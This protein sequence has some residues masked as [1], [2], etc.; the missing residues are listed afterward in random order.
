M[1]RIIVTGA[2][3]FIGRHA[4]KTLIAQNYEVHAITSRAIPERAENVTWHQVSLHD[5]R[6]TE[7]IFRT[8]RATHLLHFAW[9]VEHG[10]FWTSTE[11]YRWVATSLHL[12]KAF[13]AYGGERCVMAG[14]CAEYDWSAGRCDE[15]DTAIAPSTP[16]G[17]CKAALKALLDSFAALTGL[18]SAWGRIF[19]LYGP[20]ESRQRLVA[21]VI[22]DLLLGKVARCSH[23]EQLRDVLHVQDVAD[24]FVALLSS[25]VTGPVNIASGNAVAIKTVIRTIADEIG[26]PECLRL[27]SIPTSPTDPPILTADNLRLR[28]EVGWKAKFTL[29]TGLRDTINWWRRQ[30]EPSQEMSPD[31]KGSVM[32]GL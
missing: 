29:E 28:N 6:S 12:M 2:S 14:T 22:T 25:D 23:G 5:Q 21:S 1:K 26:R 24:A 20:Y 11:N 32:P 3:G 30:I 16:Y 4:L 10:L 19:L 31:A 8:L 15:R 18:S 7:S 13:Q 17:Q 27:G 9:Y